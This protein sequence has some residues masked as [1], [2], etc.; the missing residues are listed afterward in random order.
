MSEQVARPCACMQQAGEDS[1]FEEDRLRHEDLPR[2]NAEVPNLVLGELD[3]L[4]R[5]ATSD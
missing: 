5:P 3:E 1:Q 2:L 4:S